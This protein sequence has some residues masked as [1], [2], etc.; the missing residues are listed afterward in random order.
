MDINKALKKMCLVKDYDFI[1]NS[2]IGFRYLAKDKLHI[3]KN[4]QRFSYP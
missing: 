2:N 1:D 3:T 4:G